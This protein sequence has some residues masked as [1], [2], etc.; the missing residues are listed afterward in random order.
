MQRFLLALGAAATFG[1]SSAGAQTVLL[2][3][4]FSG[5]ATVL[6]YGLFT[7]WDVLNGTTVDLIRSGDYGISCV[8]GAGYC[9]DMSGS[10][11]ATS[12]GTLQSK[13]A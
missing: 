12:N 2:D 9:V 8:D 5:S 3:D 4:P 10:T 13:L 11:G 1:A 6:N 7:N